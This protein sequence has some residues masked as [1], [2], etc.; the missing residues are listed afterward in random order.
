MT[1][2]YVSSRFGDLSEKINEK[3]RLEGREE[4]FVN[5]DVEGWDPVYEEKLP[6]LEEM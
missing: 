4:L 6:E 2:E 1:F 5:V 3:R